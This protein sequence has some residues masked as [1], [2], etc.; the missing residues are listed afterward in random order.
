MDIFE[1]ETMDKL[2]NERRGAPP[3]HDWFISVVVPA[4]NEQEVLPEFFRRTVAVLDGI[5][6]EYEILFVNDGSTDDTLQLLRNLQAKYPR[7]SIVDLSRNF[8]KEAALTAGLDHAVGDAIVVIDA[9]LQDPP[10][11]I[12]QMI[13]EW[14]RGYDVVFARR[15][16]RAGETWLKK[17]TAKYFYQV[18]EACG[19]VK[20]PNNVGDFR[21][22]SR[23]ALDELLRLRETHRFMKGLFAWVGFDQKSIDYHRDPRFAGE[24]KWNYWKLWN[25]SLEGITSFTISPLKFS[26]YL[27]LTVAMFAFGYGGWIIFKTF[28]FGED[29]RGFPTM[30]VAVLGLGGVQLIVL[31]VMGEYLGRV[32]NEAKARPIYLTKSVYESE[33]RVD[34]NAMPRD[35]AIPSPDPSPMKR[36]IFG[37]TE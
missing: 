29:V 8:G 12:P 37:A 5:S 26:T 1:G 28:V 34:F 15:V 7:I 17:L 31:G 36:E 14:Q 16:E 27:G 32:F 13:E 25:L 35:A 4:Y 20:L 23:R 9:D 3:Q 33:A 11:L 19:P 2:S 24:T 18:M 30:M 10:E 22:L 21:L 6:A